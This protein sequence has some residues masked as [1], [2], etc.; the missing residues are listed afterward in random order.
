MAT[1]RDVA[2]VAGV[3][4]A[5]VSAF[6]TGNRHVSAELAERVGQAIAATSYRRNNL[7]SGLKSGKTK[8][9]GLVVP[10][11]TNP[12]F[13]DFVDLIQ[14]LAS[15]AGYSII[16]GVSKNGASHEHAI[17]DLLWSNKVDGTIICPA[18]SREN[19][20]RLVNAHDGVIVAV[21]NADPAGNYD[22]VTVDNRK[23]GLMAAEHLLA[24]GHRQLAIVTGPDERINATERKKGFLEGIGA[25]SAA[26]TVMLDGNFSAEGGFHACQKILLSAPRP[27]AVFVTNNQMLIGVMRALTD[28]SIEVPRSIS[29]VSVDDFPWADSFRPSLTTIRQPLGL[30]AEQCWKAFENRLKNPSSAAQAIILQPELIVRGSTAP[31]GPD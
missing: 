3:S 2:R 4:V 31:V 7:A 14:T 20:K 30:I 17:L 9:V 11:I 13:T 19:T 8:L 24:L 18:G 1:I 12:F 25:E 16:L 6:I 29:V 5:T 27:T 23:V 22:S 10:D 21:D 15:A 26:R 28:A